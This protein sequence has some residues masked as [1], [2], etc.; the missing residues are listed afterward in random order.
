[1]NKPRFLIVY[2]T[3]EGQTAKIAAF[4]ASVGKELGQPAD[5]ANVADLP[6]TFDITRYDVVMLG[7]S[8]HEHHYQRGLARFASD[9]GIGY[10]L[11]APLSSP[12]RSAP[13]AATRPRSP[14][15]ES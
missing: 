7:G 15:F 14:R 11:T 4:I 13:R 2:A 1:M 8:L 3:T 9:T 10:A 12:S 5:V 6:E